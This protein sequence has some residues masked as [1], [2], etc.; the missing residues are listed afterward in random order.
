MKNER[1]VRTNELTGRIA[2]LLVEM[3]VWTC[4]SMYVVGAWYA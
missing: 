2:G 1:D 3:Y 4:M